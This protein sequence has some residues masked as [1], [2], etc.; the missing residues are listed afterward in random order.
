MNP[1]PYIIGIRNDRVQISWRTRAGTRR[2]QPIG[3]AADLRVFLAKQQAKYKCK[4]D[5]FVIMHSSSM[6]FPEDSTS[7]EATIKLALLLTATIDS[8]C[9]ECHPAL[10]KPAPKKPAPKKRSS[11]DD[12]QLHAG[13]D[14][15]GS[16]IWHT[17]TVDGVN[18]IYWSGN[19]SER[20]AKQL[21]AECVS[22]M[23]GL[24]RNH[25]ELA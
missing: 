9:G 5:D 3:S 12:P 25:P 11:F 2:H 17:G 15:K 7:N 1:P 8:E 10:K 6:D 4:A 20:T 14:A 23:A 18:S 24:L 19:W 22:T 21:Y 13:K 16:A